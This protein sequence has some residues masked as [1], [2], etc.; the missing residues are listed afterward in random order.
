MAALP[1]YHFVHC[2]RL[3]KHVLLRHKPKGFRRIIGLIINH[4]VAAHQARVAYGY[5]PEELGIH[6]F[7]VVAAHNSAVEIGY[8][9]LIQKIFT[10]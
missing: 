8:Y 2:N 5:F 4:L 10:I 3:L 6:L 7:R 1:P 9:M